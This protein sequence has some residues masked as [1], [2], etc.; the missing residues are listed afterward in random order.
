MTG[1]QAK[2]V[3]VPFD[4]SQ[5]CVDAVKHALRIIPGD[6][7][8]FV[9]HVM[10]DYYPVH[11][12]ELYPDFTEEAY[13]TK[14]ELKMN[15]MLLEHGVDLER[16]ELHFEIGDA[17]TEIAALA[18]KLH[19]ELVVVPS[20]GRRGVKRFVLGSVAERIARLSPCPVLVVKDPA[21]FKES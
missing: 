12:A 8:V 17:G 15:Q 18:A 14:A 21:D 9:A 4:F 2:R 6:G 16:V 10:I 7:V 20:H 11:P 13:R 3:L 5:P 1:L 19:A